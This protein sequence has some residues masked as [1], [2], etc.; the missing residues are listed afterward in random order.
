MSVIKN[1]FAL[2]VLSCS[3][4]VCAGEMYEQAGISWGNKL[5]FD[6]ENGYQVVIERHLENK[7]QS[8]NAFHEMNRYAA[9]KE[10][11]KISVEGQG[12]IYD[13]ALA[14]A[15][16]REAHRRY[17]DD[18]MQQNKV[19]GTDENLKQHSKKDLP[20]FQT[21]IMRQKQERMKEV[22]ARLEAR[23]YSVLELNEEYNHNKTF[24]YDREMSQ[25]IGRALVKHWESENNQI[26]AMQTKSKL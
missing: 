23:H 21:I 18:S 26:R 5:V 11:D 12:K 15:L 9:E 16:I 2:C 17:G 4:G 25:A 8:F 10:K 1:G 6:G 7:N 20:D 3:L 24:D 14:R 13:G 22:A 19:H